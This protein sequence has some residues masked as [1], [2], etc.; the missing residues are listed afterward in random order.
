MDSSLG[1]SYSL[2]SKKI[3]GAL[4]IEGS[5]LKQ[6]PFVLHYQCVLLPTEKKFQI[7]FSVPKR[8]FKKAVERNR[9]KRLM[10]EAVRKN[11]HIIEENLPQSGE[12]LAL[13]LIYTGKKEE[14]QSFM[15]AKIDTLFS[16]LIESIKNTPAEK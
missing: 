8:R 10:R 15:L 16:R 3:I 7:V 1:K 5:H 4:F 14:N 13:F 11:K 12:Q 6:Y 9:I 2:C